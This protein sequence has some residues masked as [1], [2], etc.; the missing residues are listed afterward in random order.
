M[1]DFKSVFAVRLAEMLEF[2]EAIGYR[3]DTHKAYL[4]KFDEYC[5]N[6]YLAEAE[7]TDNIVL[8]WSDSEQGSGVG[9][10]QAIR[11]F[12]EY[13]LSMGENAYILPEG[14]TSQKSNFSAY[15]FADK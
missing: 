8:A 4:M 15:V 2:R 7:L 14:Y 13:L 11:A 9:A 6:N 5:R 12:G 1:N 3:A 10:N